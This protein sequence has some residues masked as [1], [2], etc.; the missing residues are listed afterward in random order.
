M[1]L[2]PFL[3]KHYMMTI[4]GV[5]WYAKRENKTYEKNFSQSLNDLFAL[6]KFHILQI[7]NLA[8]NKIFSGITFLMNTLHIS[9]MLLVLLKYKIKNRMCNVKFEIEIKK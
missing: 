2:K 4:N 6:K 9:L 5:L 8:S 3:L 7:G 1:I